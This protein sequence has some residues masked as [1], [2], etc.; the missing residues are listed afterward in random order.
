MHFFQ[1]FLAGFAL[2]L[3]SLVTNAQTVLTEGTNLHADASLA[4]GR[5]AFDLLGGIWILP[6]NGGQ[7]AELPNTVL[8]ARSPR[9]SP[10]G[11]F[12]L[13]QSAAVEGNQ[14]WLHDIGNKQPRRL[15]NGKH[16]EQYASWHPDGDR[17]VFSS[18][19]Q[20]RGLDLWEH[21]LATGL[22][23]RLTSSIGDETEAY[24]SA[25]G[26]HLAYV[27][28][29]DQGWSLMLR[30]HGEPDQRLL[31]SNRSIHAPS[32]RP[33]GTLI[34]FLSETEN[35]YSLDMA[36]L[37]EP[38]VIRRYGDT[39]DD[40]FL[41]PVSW[42]DRQ[43][44]IY[45]ADGQIMSRNFDSRRST[46]VRFRASIGNQVRLGQRKGTSRQL[47]V[48]TPPSHKLV[49]RAA[50]LY[51][52]LGSTYRYGVD[53]VVDGGK[54][55]AVDSQREWPD[56]TLLD[57][58]NV[59]ILPG[60]IDLY[61][62][63]PSGDNKAVGASLLA[64]G[65]TTLIADDPTGTLLPDLWH[66]E[67]NPG[68]R[69]I[70]AANI[71]TT[72]V[73]NSKNYFLATVPSRTRLERAP[74]Q[75]VRRWQESGIP[76]LAENWT[77]GLGLGVDLLLGANTLPAS[78]SGR[79]YQDMRLTVGH[80]PLILVSGLADAGTPGLLP[81]LDSRQAINLGHNKATPRHPARLVQLAAEH[82]SIVLGSKPSGL[83]PGLALHAEFRALAAA[84]LSSHEVLRSASSNI[85]NLLGLEQQLGRVTP[86]AF[87]DL[88]LV[89]GDPLASISDALNIVAVVRNG[90]FY[91]LVSLL[92][93]ATA[94]PIVE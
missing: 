51:D 18:A 17:V 43:R 77:I 48:I 22:R 60:F 80:A 74:L 81:L 45:S 68:P 5:I 50:R 55:G 85:G 65:V 24:W 57:L 10:S 3:I 41:S 69:L 56:A 49:I 72:K 82:S 13:Y 37:S 36:I 1:T 9:W 86:G 64:Y 6:G 78:P 47:P 46:P 53:V 20:D 59:T 4:D 8:P 15:S 89:A 44:M 7:A 62:A 2:V 25:N 73:E 58:G 23:W 84:G 29:D 70:P 38:P 83:P 31:Q 35:G 30:R 39:E 33:D 63:L 28:R 42:L 52:G 11:Q 32:W 12:L 67:D 54:I 66:G 16:S 76:V 71:S 40:L 91:S 34:T 27:S 21:D 94:V 79:Q 87:A 93:R 26:R 14:L 75:L 61:S 19:T 88:V 92:E 90:R